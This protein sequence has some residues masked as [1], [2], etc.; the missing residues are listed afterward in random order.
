M[1]QQIYEAVRNCIVHH[2]IFQNFTN[3][4]YTRKKNN[5]IFCMHHILLSDTQDVTG[6]ALKHRNSC[7]KTALKKFAKSDK[8]CLFLPYRKLVRFSINPPCL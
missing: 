5:N 1:G 8:V 7:Y 2:H 6:H 3:I 4:M